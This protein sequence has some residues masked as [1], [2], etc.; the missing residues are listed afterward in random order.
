[1]IEVDYTQ[2]P[3]GIYKRISI[4][5][6]TG[7]GVSI[8]VQN[9]LTTGYSNLK[10]IPIIDTYTDIGLSGKTTDRPD[11]QRMMADLRSGR[12]RCVLIAK[13]DRLTR[14]SLHMLQF[15]EEAERNDWRLISVA[16]SFD[17]NTPS[18]KLVITILVAMA[19]FER[20]RIVERI[21][22]AHNYKVTE[23][24]RT[25]SRPPYG[26]QINKDKK[27]IQNPKEARIIKDIFKQAIAGTPPIQ[28]AKEHS[29]NHCTVL[30]RIRNPAYQGTYA[31]KENEVSGTIIEPILTKEEWDEAQEKIKKWSKPKLASPKN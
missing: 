9:H 12:I 8:E 5:E 10:T 23:Q 22:Q 31:H 3:T 29:M 13:L 7:R 6:K 24:H 15:I 30:H 1:M 20:E 27:L 14:S 21:T 19:T 18:G 2:L 11:F 17:S 26:Y 28:I 25:V 4:E 16:E